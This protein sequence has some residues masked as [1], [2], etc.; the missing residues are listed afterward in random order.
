MLT[1]LLRDLHLEQRQPILLLMLRTAVRAMDC[2][3][4]APNFS[5]VH[6]VNMPYFTTDAYSRIWWVCAEIET[7]VS[8]TA[9]YSKEHYSRRKCSD[10]ALDAKHR[11]EPRASLKSLD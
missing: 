3:P 4:Q 5:V 9:T 7:L 1:V 6:D 10:E 8:F 11:S 2:L